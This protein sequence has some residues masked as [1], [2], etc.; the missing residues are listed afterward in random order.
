MCTC[1]VFTFNSITQRQLE[2]ATPTQG[3]TAAAHST[4]AAVACRGLCAD[5]S[6]CV[7]ACDMGM[8]Y[9]WIFLLLL[10]L[11]SPVARR[12]IFM[13]HSS[14]DAFEHVVA[15]NFLFPRLLSHFPVVSCAPLRTPRLRAF[16]LRSLL[17]T[18]R[19]SL[20]ESIISFGCACT[21]PQ[22]QPHRQPGEGGVAQQ[23]FSLSHSATH[24]LSPSSLLFCF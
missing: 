10:L 17:A 12:F 14:L 15:F 6:V 8:F 7:C 20:P 22:P 19:H 4:S 21:A 18:H 11:L 3:T 2:A 5:M 16:S 1:C 13:F 9:A 23:Y 24:S